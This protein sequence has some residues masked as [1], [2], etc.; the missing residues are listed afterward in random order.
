MSVAIH[1]FGQ[2][3]CPCASLRR[4]NSLLANINIDD[5]LFVF[6]KKKCIAEVLKVNWILFQKVLKKFDK[7]YGLKFYT[8]NEIVFRNWF[9]NRVTVI[10][11]Y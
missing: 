11:I 3:T 7:I 6:M 4:Y 5:L 10:K 2:Y 1:D 8:S 9:H